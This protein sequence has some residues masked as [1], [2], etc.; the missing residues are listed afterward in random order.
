MADLILKLAGNPGVAHIGIVAVVLLVR[1]WLSYKPKLSVYQGSDGLEGVGFAI[2]QSMG[3][4]TA[5]RV[6][7]G[8]A[9]SPRVFLP[10][11]GSKLVFLVM[12][13]L[14]ASTLHAVGI[15]EFWRTADGYGRLFIAGL[16]ALV[17]GAVLPMVVWISFFH[18]VT[19]EDNRITV[20]TQTLRRQ[21]AKLSDVRG[22]RMAK[23]RPLYEVELAD[24]SVMKIYKFISHREE[25]LAIL[26]AAARG[27]FG[28]GKNQMVR[29]H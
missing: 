6:I 3:S 1:F 22:V 25:L 20:V 17:G 24:G 7:D 8:S 23:E 15:G 27:P 10:T 29:P 26:Q 16:F 14:A 11:I 2:F 5:P 18:R 13:G 21:T 12:F 28:D 4:R 9:R 19:L